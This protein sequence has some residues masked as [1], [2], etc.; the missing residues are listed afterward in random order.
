MSKPEILDKKPLTIMELK[1]ELEKAQ[2]RDEELGF[3]AGKALDYAN[4][5]VSLS[6]KAHDELKKKL[7]DLNIPRLK[8]DQQAKIVD[9]LPK[10]VAELDVI[11][12]GYT[13]T[14]NKE[15][16]QKIIN[17]VKEFLKK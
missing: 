9:M 16:K 11:L 3:R 4:T 13:I 10:S 14:V 7:E 1:S 12:Q 5:F 17:V 6:K 15:N 8:E 2:K